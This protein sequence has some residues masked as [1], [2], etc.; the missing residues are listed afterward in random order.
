ML[1][2][3]FVL[4]RIKDELCVAS[5]PLEKTDEEIVDYL[6]RNALKKFES[7]GVIQTHSGG[8]K[9]TYIKINNEYLLDELNKLNV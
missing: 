4:E 2:W 1:N 7:A 3:S 5:Q 8:M 9:G 6:K